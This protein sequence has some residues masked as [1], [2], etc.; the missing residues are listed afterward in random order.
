LEP[1][2]VGTML[3]V[4]ELGMQPGDKV[5]AESGQL[6]WMSPRRREAGAAGIAI[7]ILSGG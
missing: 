3:P 4:L 6:A 5:F 2:I 7:D 1:K